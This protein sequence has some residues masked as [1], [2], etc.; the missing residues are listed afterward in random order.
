MGDRM[1]KKRVIIKYVVGVGIAAAIFFA[2]AFSQGLFRKADRVEFFRTLSDCFLFP[3]VFLGGIG[4]LSWIAQKGTFD[5]LSYGFS[6]IFGRMIHHGERQES[7]Y[8]YKVRK[9]TEETEWL[10]HFFVIGLVCFAASAGCLL[11]Y[12]AG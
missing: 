9:G 5:M 10:K 1:G 11:P 3:A 7:Y 8:E 2:G 12:Y 6:T 4:A